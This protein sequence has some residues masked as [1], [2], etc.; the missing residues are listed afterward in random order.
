MFT[1]TDRRGDR[2]HLMSGV[3]VALACLVAA[4]SGTAHDLSAREGKREIVRLQGYREKLPPGL[5]TQRELVLSILGVEHKFHLTDWRRF[6][7]TDDQPPEET[8]PAKFGLQAERSVLVKIAGA[9][10]EQRVTILGE[11]RATSSD[12]FVLAV[13]LCPAE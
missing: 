8:E 4:S 6:R 13:D 3:V 10:P 1:N 7:L 9:R 11:R 2:G 5:R 12:I